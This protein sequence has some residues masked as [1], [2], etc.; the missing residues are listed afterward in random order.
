VAS[1]EEKNHGL[2]YATGHGRMC[3]DCGSPMAGCSCRQKKDPPGGDGVVRISRETKGRKGKVVTVITGLTLDEE[4]LH[5][6]AREL[7]Q[8]CGT[9]GALK[10]RILEIQGDHRDMLVKELESRGCRVKRSGG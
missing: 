5:T 7:K 1:G 2:V 8:K 9:G 3:P 4:G 6:L 10:D